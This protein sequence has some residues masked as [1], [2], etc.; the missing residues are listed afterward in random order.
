M[1]DNTKKTLSVEVPL[2]FDAKANTVRA[3]MH[4]LQQG[5]EHLFKAYGTHVSNQPPKVVIEVP[6]VV[7]DSNPVHTETRVYEDT[8][9]DAIEE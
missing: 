4:G 3:I 2:A 1:D 8:K 7:V 6:S 9:N 5:I